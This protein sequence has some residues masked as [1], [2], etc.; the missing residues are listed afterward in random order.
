MFAAP[1]P[2]GTPPLLA[3]NQVSKSFGHVQAL[4]NVSFELEAGEV[5]CVVGENGA[6]KSTL[7]NALYGFNRP[8][9]GTILIDGRQVDIDSPGTALSLGIGMVHQHLMLIPGMTVLQNIAL[10]LKLASSS[11]RRELQGKVTRIMSGMGVSLPLDAIVGDMAMGQRQQVEILKALVRDARIVILDEPTSV[12]SPLEIEKLGLIVRALAK[13]GTAIVLITHKLR[14][15]I[16]FSDRVT[17]MRAG[18]VVSSGVTAGYAFADIVHHMFGSSS[19][20][21]AND[22]AAD[23]LAEIGPIRVS[24]HNLRA[25]D[26]RGRPAVE[27]VS[28]EIMAGEILGIAG[29]SGNGQSHLCEALAGTRSHTGA[30]VLDNKQLDQC[31]PEERRA[32][33]LSYIPEER[34]DGLAM[35]LTVAE[36]LYLNKFVSPGFSSLG[37]VNRSALE[38][39]ASQL[40][41]KFTIPE[42][43][44]TSPTRLLSGGNQQRIALAKALDSGPGFVVASQPTIGL[45]LRTIEFVQSTLI[46]LRD[47]G[48]SILYVSTEL[49]ELFALADRIAVMYRGKFAK[50]VNRSE[51]S[52]EVLGPLMIAGEVVRE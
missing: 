11:E 33:G 39:R 32:N 29:V 37:I 38:T 22:K 26:D 2:I 44:M 8:D 34:F 30:I 35:P 31:R 3:V 20:A 52:R 28:F 41:R 45:D 27:G 5:H 9:T 43:R 47:S 51:F 50:I 46:A 15:A 13:D 7:M 17:I 25:N 42:D 36:N 12:L 49:E 19:H 21:S 1:Q 10:G 48:T 4:D 14:E 6:G 16:D 24:V 18:T 23:R 40:A